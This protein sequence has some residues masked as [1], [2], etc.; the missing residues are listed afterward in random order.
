MLDKEKLRTLFVINFVAYV[1]ML[2]FGNETVSLVFLLSLL[3]IGT[4]HFS[5]TGNRIILNIRGN[6]DTPEISSLLK[7][8][9]Q[10]NDA[11]KY[12]ASLGSDDFIRFVRLMVEV[13]DAKDQKALKE[14]RK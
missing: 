14:T 2:V 10:L 12:G 5:T 9:E 11:V 4:I 8:E 7:K 1:A 6:L 13:R 3:V